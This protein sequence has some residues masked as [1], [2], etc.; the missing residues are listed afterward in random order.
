[1]RSTYKPKV[2]VPE[3]RLVVLD[4]CDLRRSEYGAVCIFKSCKL[5]PCYCLM[6]R[7]PSFCYRLVDYTLVLIS[8]EFISLCCDMLILRVY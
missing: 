4:K 8:I 7:Q 5:L 1:M 3:F 6:Y 2:D